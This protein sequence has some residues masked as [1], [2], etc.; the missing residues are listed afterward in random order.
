MTNQ[1]WG[2]GLDFWRP[3]FETSRHRLGIHPHRSWPGPSRAQ[4]V[5]VRPPALARKAHAPLSLI[6]ISEPT[7]PEPI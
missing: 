3:A 1:P 5:C 4:E 7:R 2:S 6:H